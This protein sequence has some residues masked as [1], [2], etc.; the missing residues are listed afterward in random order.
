[1]PEIPTLSLKQLQFN[2]A[3]F[4]PILYT[5]KRADLSVLE[6]S[7][8]KKEKR[9]N[10]AYEEKNKIDIALGQIES[11]LNEKETEWFQQ[12]KNDINKDIEDNINIDNPGAAYR[13]ALLASG[14]VLKDPALQG[15]IKANEAYKKRFEELDK[16]VASGYIT[17]N[18]KDWIVATNPYS[19]VDKYDANGNIIAGDPWKLN[20]EPVKDITLLEAVTL[21]EQTIKSDKISRGGTSI[22]QTNLT[23]SNWRSSNQ[24]TT[25]EE[26]RDQ[27]RSYI[28]SG[29]GK[30]QALQF[31]HSNIWK[32]EEAKKALENA[33]KNGL[34]EEIDSAKRAL[35]DAEKS[36]VINNGQIVDNYID[37]YLESAKVHIKN[38]AHKEDL[39][40]TDV[41]SIGGSG[42]RSIST[43]SGNFGSSVPMQYGTQ[44]G[45]RI[46]M[47]EQGTIEKSLE[48]AK[49]A[50]DRFG[51]DIEL[52]E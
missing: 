8:A 19:Y 4:N 1:M 13:T 25:E 28:S 14:K 21:A 46:N 50:C 26:I 5:P 3:V 42:G 41:N 12:Y 49:K 30:D 6:R 23:N 45:P 20:K 36:V 16:Q 37:F 44:G 17:S 22:D 9:T 35:E 10:K 38:A 15:R 34:Q 39:Y 11:Q 51:N 32:Y 27:L 43:S 52:A 33:T 18:T 7:L 2:P 48:I 40:I 29:L 47:E 31:Y 24:K